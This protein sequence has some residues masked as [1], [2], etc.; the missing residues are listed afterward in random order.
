MQDW[1]LKK[2]IF[3]VMMHTNQNKINPYIRNG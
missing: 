2:V 3:N 1:I